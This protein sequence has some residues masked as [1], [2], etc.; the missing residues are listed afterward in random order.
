MD[1]ATAVVLII[2]ALIASI[3]TV[4][5]MTDQNRIDEKEKT[6]RLAL[7]VE[8]KRLDIFGKDIK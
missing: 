7:E 8:M 1:P 2:L 3:S 5:V 6:K 4:M